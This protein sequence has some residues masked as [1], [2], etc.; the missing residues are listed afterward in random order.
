M[1]KCLLIV[2][3]ATQCVCLQP[4]HPESPQRRSQLIRLLKQQVD[5]EKQK[6]KR[7]GGFS[8]HLGPF[9]PGNETLWKSVL[10]LYW[11]QL[12]IAAKGN[13]VISEL[14]VVLN[15][16]KLSNSVRFQAGL[17]LAF[18]DDPQIL[19]AYH[20]ATRAG[21]IDG[22]QLYW[23]LAT[24]LPRVKQE[25]ADFVRGEEDK[26]LVQWLDRL[27][28]REFSEL[29]LDLLDEKM[30]RDQERQ[31]EFFGNDLAI[32]RWLNVLHGQDFDVVLAREAPEALGLRNRELAKGY[33]P[34]IVFAYV[35]E[36]GIVDDH[37]IAAAFSEPKDRAACKE[38]IR[39]LDGDSWHPIPRAEYT[40]KA[41]FHAW[42]W[43]NRAKFKYDFGK[44]RFVIPK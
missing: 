14:I 17:D 27:V 9:I 11:A 23:C 19:R 26:L 29:R 36:G 25:P 38:L 3:L 28:D 18:F 12:K 15:D 16:E 22:T 33:D 41:Q 35:L 39:A 8:W 2:V 7:S 21:M 20:K 1:N 44:H 32:L 6:L 42:Y 34:A 43:E 5:D 24:H 13:D 30:R 4:R 31:E 10:P 40:W 37:A